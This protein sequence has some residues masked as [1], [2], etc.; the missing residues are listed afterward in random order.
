MTVLVELMSFV[1]SYHFMGHMYL[2]G[3]VGVPTPMDS[4][5]CAVFH[6]SSWQQN[7]EGR[8]PKALR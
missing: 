3:F 5:L 4:L 6:H 2:F 8:N 1:T 7:R